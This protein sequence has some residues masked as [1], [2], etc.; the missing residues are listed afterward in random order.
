MDEKQVKDWVVPS[1]VIYDLVNFFSHVNDNVKELF[2]RT[3][4][5]L[6]ISLC[7]FQKKTYLTPYN[8]NITAVLH[9]CDGERQNQHIL[10]SSNTNTMVKSNNGITS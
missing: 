5:Y 2:R 10:H 9:G 4:C 8:H 7:L 1:G 3:S 6:Q